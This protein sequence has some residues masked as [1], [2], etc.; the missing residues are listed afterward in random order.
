MQRY[1]PFKKKKK[2]KEELFPVDQPAVQ[3]SLHRDTEG[4]K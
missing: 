4:A 3:L 1:K 2:K